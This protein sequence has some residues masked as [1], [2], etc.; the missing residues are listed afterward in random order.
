MKMAY[1]T[2][3]NTSISLVLVLGVVRELNSEKILHRD[4]L[5]ACFP[6]DIMGVPLCL[7]E[8]VKNLG[9]LF[10]PGFSLS[11][12]EQSFCKSFLSNS[13]TSDR[14]GGFLLMM[15]LYLYPM[16]LSVVRVLAI[17]SVVPNFHP[18]T[19]NFVKQFGC[20]LAVDAPTV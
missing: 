17:A 5:K 14:S 7:A 8:S 2:S 3:M 18:S 15:F 16:L 4:R 1:V 19:Q 12:H 20:R 11:M 10:D 9:L 6:I 13:G